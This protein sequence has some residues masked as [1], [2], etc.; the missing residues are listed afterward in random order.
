[1]L[2]KCIFIV[3]SFER[4]GPESQQSIYG[5]FEE[6]KDA[7]KC[8]N[9][10]LSSEKEGGYFSNDKYSSFRNSTM[11][12]TIIAAIGGSVKPTQWC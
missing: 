2:E 3:Q 8:F 6:M 1:M 5:V 9:K 10:V 12:L 7:I 11:F 4:I